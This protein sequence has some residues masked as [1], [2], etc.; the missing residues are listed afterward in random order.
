MRVNNNH[1]ADRNLFGNRDLLIKV[2]LVAAT[3]SPRGI[4]MTYIE[5]ATLHKNMTDQTIETTPKY[6]RITLRIV[7]N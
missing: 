3:L 5:T 1:V 7:Y 2:K 4:A 6:T